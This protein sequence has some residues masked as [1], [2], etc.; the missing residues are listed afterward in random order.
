MPSDINRSTHRNSQ[1]GYHLAC[2]GN[3]MINGCTTSSGQ[4]SPWH[5]HTPLTSLDSLYKGIQ[6]GP[7]YQNITLVIFQISLKLALSFTCLQTKLCPVPAPWTST[8]KCL[9]NI[10]C[11]YSTYRQYSTFSNTATNSWAFLFSL[12]TSLCYWAFPHKIN[13]Y[14]FY[15]SLSSWP[16]HAC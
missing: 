1:S 16:I 6:L 5:I 3:Q 9:I 12:R 15:L 8:A 11:S 14:L 13:G 4:A 2:H 10:C 7:K